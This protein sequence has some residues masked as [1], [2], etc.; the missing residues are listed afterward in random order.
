MS[1]SKQLMAGWYGA[2]AVSGLGFGLLGERRPFGEDILAHPLILYCLAVAGG[3]LV[4]RFGS[5]RPV[6]QIIPER[7][8]GRG[9]ALG[10]VMF[11]VGNFIAAHL[12]V[13]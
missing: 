13:R 4:L 12:I 7:A 3:L 10:L 5:G 9:C 8:L 11:L 6:P 1:R 2:M